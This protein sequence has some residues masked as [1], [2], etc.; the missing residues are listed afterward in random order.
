MFSWRKKSA[1]S[2]FFNKEIPPFS[3]LSITSYVFHNQTKSSLD[4]KV[5]T[6]FT[7]CQIGSFMGQNRNL[8]KP[9]FM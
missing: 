5:K 8:Q 7:W 2:H 6:K 9:G 1:F 4:R 3:K